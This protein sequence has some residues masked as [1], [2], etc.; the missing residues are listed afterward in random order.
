MPWP[1]FDLDDHGLEIVGHIDSGLP[2]FAVPDVGL[3]RYLDLVGPAVGVLLIGFAEG[4]GAARTYAA[5][6][7]YDIDAD[8]ELSGMGRPTWARG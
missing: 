8:R 7:G 6:E 3:S 4:L 2:A 5:K 1:L